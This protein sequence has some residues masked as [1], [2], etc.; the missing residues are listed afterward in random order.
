MTLGARGS[1][2]IDRVAIAAGGTA[3]VKAGTVA[4]VGMRAVIWRG[5]PRAGIM[6]GVTRCPS[7]QPS[8]EC[9]FGM[10]GR[11]ERRCTSVGIVHMTLRTGNINVRPGE[12]E[13]GQVVVERGRV[14]GRGG[15]TLAAIRT[16]APAM[17]IIFRMT[18]I[19]CGWEA[20]EY[21]VGV[22]IRTRNRSMRAGQGKGR[23][24]VVECH[25][26]P[27]GG[28]MAFRTICAKGSVVMVVFCMATVTG[29]GETFEGIVDMAAGA[30][31]GGM[32]PGQR[33]SGG[34]VIECGWLP[35]VGGVAASAV[36]SQLPIMRVILGVAGITVGRCS[37]EGFRGV[38]FFARDHS[39]AAQQFE[40]N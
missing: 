36:S 32:L 2:Q 4:R 3:V 19:A 35:S 25:R 39:V 1:R 26:Q 14:P 24:V 40:S 33:K 23:C 5:H 15:M 18:T 34:V 16:E 13:G 29:Q 6:A 7:E 37:F 27:A 38:T 22:A 31:G 11:A 17:R 21:I 12:R 10:T 28:Q 9:R 8:M 20:G 30:Q